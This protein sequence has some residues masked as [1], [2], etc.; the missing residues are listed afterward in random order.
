MLLPRED[1]PEDFLVEHVNCCLYFCKQQSD[2]I[3]QNLDLF[4]KIQEVEQKRMLRLQ[5]L[6][7]EHY[8]RVCAIQEI[9]DEDRIQPFGLKVLCRNIMIIIIYRVVLGLAVWSLS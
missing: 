6:C 8:V 4:G 7:V 1:I 9:D 2:T 3:S 5:D